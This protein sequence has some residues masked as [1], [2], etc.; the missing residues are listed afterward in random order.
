MHGMVPP[1]PQTQ[2]SQA[3]FA[4]IY[5][6]KRN[7]KKDKRQSKRSNKRFPAGCVEIKR[8][9]EEAIQDALINEKKFAAIV[10]GPSKSSEGQFIYYL[11]EWL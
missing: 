11:Q 2:V 4:V 10:V 7:A 8:D 3:H 6:P 9:K 1:D 5:L